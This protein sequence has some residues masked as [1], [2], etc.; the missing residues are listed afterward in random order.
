MKRMITALSLIICMVALAGCRHSLVF[1]RQVRA[2]GDI[3]TESY[4]IKD[5][6]GLTIDGLMKNVEL[7][8][9]QGRYMVEIEADSNY[10][11]ELKVDKRGDNLR[12]SIDEDRKLTDDIR[13]IIS[14]PEFI[15]LDIRGAM[16]LNSVGE[17]AGDRLRIE[18]SG[19]VE[20]DLELDYDEVKMNVSGAAKTDLYGRA[21]E[22]SADCAGATEIDALKLDTKRATISVSGA[23]DVKIY[24]EDYLDANIS[25]AGTIKYSGNPE[26]EKGVSGVGSVKRMDD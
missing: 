25:G 10:F 21:D 26:V 6:T 5:F 22:F 24:C 18:V 13:V 9:R 23:G 20:A 4:D 2:S 17:L 15:N 3:K 19:A 1:A 8:L 7:E 16:E 12:I 14:A 11:K